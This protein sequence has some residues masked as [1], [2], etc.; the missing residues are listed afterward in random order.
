V[1]VAP[2]VVSLAVADS[3]AVDSL[4]VADSA[5]DSLA[6]MGVEE[7]QVLAFHHPCVIAVP[8]RVLAQLQ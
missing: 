2:A 3:R 4:A 6:V 1:E 8:K 5:E 7:V